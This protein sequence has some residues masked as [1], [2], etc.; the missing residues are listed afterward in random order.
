[1]LFDFASLGA[2][3]G[4]MEVSS[5]V[6]GLREEGPSTTALEV[7]IAWTFLGAGRES[8]REFSSSAGMVPEARFG[9]E[10]PR[11]KSA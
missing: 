2:R 7:E 6:F 3:E 9:R 4:G 5:G 8:R 10:R 1:M 11:P